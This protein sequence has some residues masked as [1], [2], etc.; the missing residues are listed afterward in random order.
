[1]YCVPSHQYSGSVTSVTIRTG[2]PLAANVCECT[3]SGLAVGPRVSSPHIGT[4]D[5]LES[6]MILGICNNAQL[7]SLTLE[8]LICLRSYVVNVTHEFTN[9]HPL[10]HLCRNPSN[11]NAAVAC[12]GN[13]ISQH[14][15]QLH[16]K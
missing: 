13:S 1:M 4:R 10:F 8:S 5:V 16:V 12:E 11:I 7:S 15:L 9:T 3:V 14:H 2:Q 6:L